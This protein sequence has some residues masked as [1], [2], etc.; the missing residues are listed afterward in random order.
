MKILLIGEYS[1]LHNSLKEGLK[2]LGHEVVL[3]GNGDLFKN[4]PVDISIDSP[5]ASKY[6]PLFIRK[7]FF[8]LF[9]IDLWD[10]EKVRKLK[11]N[12]PNFHGYNV[13]QLINEDAFSLQPKI[14][15]KYIS[16][17]KNQNEQLYL[18]TCGDDNI[19]I[20]H[21]L[22]NNDKY[23]ILTPYLKDNSLKKNYYYSLKYTLKSYQDLHEFIFKIIKG[24]IASDIDYH[25]PLRQH[26]KYLG[27][28]PNPINI[29][30]LEYS[31]LNITNKI[32][33]FHGV[34]SKN[35]IK[36]GNKFFDEA[37]DIIKSKYAEKVSIIRTEDLPYNQYIEAFNKAHIVLDQV[38]AYDQGYN[39]LE[40]MAKGKVVFTGAE[41]EWLDYYN[42][43]ENTVAINALPETE[44]IVGKLTW[45]IENPSNI[46]VISKNA[47]TF[48]ER[49]HHYITIAKRYL[50]TWEENAN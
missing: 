6:L 26:K 43:E 24:V 17:L 35:Y 21:Y 29:D 40:A 9:K 19:S 33:I 2:S 39:A 30:K 3:V 14:Q 50:K 20:N 10:Y 11:K 25:L 41:Q 8:K 5:L 16:I 31:E 44:A 13:V 12:I 22:Q 7:L 18:L 15:K 37:L 38:Y 23:S 42:L 28:I 47:R 48:I 4:Y 32:T 49:E 45:L 27:L 46:L 36:K 34:N 1:R